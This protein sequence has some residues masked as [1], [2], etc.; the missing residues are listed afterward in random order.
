LL[1]RCLEKDPRLRLRDIGDA[2]FELADDAGEPTTVSASP[3]RNTWGAQSIWLGA[4][5]LTMLA[6]VA[7]W[8]LRPSPPGR[9]AV[10]RFAIALPEGQR[11][12]GVLRRLAVSP[13][14]TQIV[15]C[16]DN[17]LYRRTLDDPEIR[18]IPGT[19]EDPEFPEFSPDGRWIAFVGFDAASQRAV[20]KRI[21]ATGG[22]SE[23]ILELGVAQNVKGWTPTDSSLSWSSDE[24]L[25]SGPTGIWAVMVGGG[26][27]SLVSVDPAVEIATFP[28]LIGDGR[29]VL[30]TLKRVGGAGIEA[31]SIV[32]QDVTSGSRTEI[33]RAGRLGI[34]LPSGHLVYLRGTDLLAVGFDERR[35]RVSGDPIIV[36]TGV[37]GQLAVSRSGTVAYQLATSAVSRVPVWVNRDGREDP[38]AVP[39]QSVTTLRVSPDGSRLAM[40]NG[41]EVRVWN[42]DKATMMRLSE[43]GGGHWDVAWTPDS[44]RLVFSLGPA[45]IGG[46]ILVKAADGSG[47]ATVLTPTPGGF[48][49]AVSHDGKYV[50]FHRGAGELMIQPMDPAASSRSVVKGLALNGAFSPDGRWIAYQAYEAGL[51]EIFVRAFPDAVAGRWQV[52]SGGGKYPVWSPDG[53]ELFFINAAGLLTGVSVDSQQ[54]FATGPPVKLFGTERYAANSNSRPFDI[55]HD[56]KRFVFAKP[57]AGRAR[58]TISVVTNWLTE[59]AAKAGAQQAQPGQ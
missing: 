46:Q 54:G 52:S 10:T 20:L 29:H 28:R 57:E 35:L 9:G 14:G 25:G 6:G 8:V 18:A 26:V 41:T 50:L 32:A 40:T 37:T 24:I 55:S 42:F 53:R 3:P 47:A 51:S 31:S 19:N 22:T 4:L 44:Q 38:I 48:P 5:V 17:Q 45:P 1:H 16:A 2:R 39:A 34:P 27:R 30:F 43:T 12:T 49:N 58:P 21:L 23:T 36:A 33:V 15:F 56:G 59:V 7:G 13:D 11:F